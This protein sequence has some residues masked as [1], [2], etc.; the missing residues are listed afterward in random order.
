MDHAVQICIVQG[1][2]VLQLHHSHKFNCLYKGSEISKTLVSL[3]QNRSLLFVQ[4]LWNTYSISNL[5]KVKKSCNYFIENV[6]T[7]SRLP[8]PP[9]TYFLALKKKKNWIW[10]ARYL[11]LSAWTWANDQAQAKVKSLKGTPAAVQSEGSLGKVP[12]CD[13]HRMWRRYFP[14]PTHFIL[15]L[16]V[17]M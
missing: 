4:V 12:R 10:H 6:N 7:C 17:H 1:S 3:G 5:P 2:T 13:I 16:D 14:L 9:Y 8:T 15:L 11:L